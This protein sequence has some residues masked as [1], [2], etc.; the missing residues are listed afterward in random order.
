MYYVML[1]AI[2]GNQNAFLQKIMEIGR[3]GGR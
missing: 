1:V 3:S 2:F